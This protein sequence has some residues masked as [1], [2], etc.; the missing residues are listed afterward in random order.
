VTCGKMLKSNLQQ[1]LA[2][3]SAGEKVPQVW[4]LMGRKAGDNT[5]VLALAEALGWP[6]EIKK[7]VY[8][9]YELIANLV[10]GATLSGVVGEASSSLGPPWP[11]LVISAGRRNEPV[12]RWIQRQADSSVRL[13]HIGRPWAALQRFDLIVTTPQYQLPDRPN[14]V[15]NMLP[16]HRV[17]DARLASE[18]RKWTPRFAHLPRPWIAVLLGGDSGPFVF[19]P[20]KGARLG[21]QINQMAKDTGGAVLVSDSARTPEAALD[22]FQSELDVPALVYRWQATDGE[23]P[24]FAYLAVADTIVVTGESMSMLTEACATRKP[25]IVFDLSDKICTD[26]A[27]GQQNPGSKTECQPWWRLRHN[28]RFKPLSHRLAMRFGPKR[29]RRDIGAIQERLVASGRA[30]WLGQSFAGE[31]HPLP[32]GDLDRAVERVRGLFKP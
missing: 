3:D 16:L 11:D 15:R 5:Q 23:N 6:F 8:R 13:V 27:G 2:P 30:V 17:T 7:F 14:V 19:T 18:S 32:V 1:S 31:S 12:A 29:L 24:Y 4:L 25:L 26:E 28:F 22:A 20:E 9:K 10:F 21:R